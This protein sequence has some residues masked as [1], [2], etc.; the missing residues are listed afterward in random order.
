VSRQWHPLFAYLLGLLVEDHYEVRTEVPVS[1]LPRRADLL[2]VHRQPGKS[3][4]FQ[5]LWSHLTEWNLLE[6]KGL[7]DAAEET[8]LELLVH[9]GTGLTY[10]FN[11]ERQTRKEPLLTNRQFSFWYL[12]P[13][14]GD[15]FLGHARLRTALD[16]QTNGLWRGSVWGHPVWL[17]AYR[18]SAVE[19]DTIPLHLLAREPGAPRALGE[20]IVRQPN[21]L[22]RFAGWCSALQPH[23]W[24]E[25]RRMSGTTLDGPQIDWEA[26]A[27]ITPLD[28]A[29]R[30]LPPAH[31]VEILSGVLPVEQLVSLLAQVYPPDQ[32]MQLL[33]HSLPADRVIEEIG[34][35]K[36]IE[37]LL[38]HAT[39][40]QLRELHRRTQE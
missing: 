4:P 15:T 2:L 19:E 37:A 23:L 27:R 34:T 18:E 8:D 35:D 36:V 11:E 22:Q 14:L 28:G 16:Y 40:E 5:G 32:V 26:V 10:R 3:S 33:A 6:F 29:V 31:V 38:K 7:T 12:V 25:I 39:P 13:R 21:L 20:L 24:E 17:L 1:D 9:V 30:V